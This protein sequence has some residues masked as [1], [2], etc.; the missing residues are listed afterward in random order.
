MS[1]FLDS[2]DRGLTEEEISILRGSNYDKKDSDVIQEILEQEKNRLLQ[3]HL[4]INVSANASTLS[5][6]SDYGIQ[7]K[8]PSVELPTDS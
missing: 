7:R 1:N 8:L 4:R 3:S 5:P 2:N 6:L